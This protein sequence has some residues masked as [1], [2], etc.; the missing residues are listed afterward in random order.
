MGATPAA[1]VSAASAR[2]GD[3]LSTY[4][5]GVVSAANAAALALGVRPGITAKE[6]ARLMLQTGV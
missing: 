4:R 3:A 2:I 5:D 6:A 1:A